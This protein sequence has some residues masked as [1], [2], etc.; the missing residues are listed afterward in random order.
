MISKEHRQQIKLGKNTN[1]D[2]P[3]FSQDCQTDF[4]SRPVT[5]PCQ[6]KFVH[7]MMHV[8][9]PVSLSK[10]RNEIMQRKQVLKRGQLV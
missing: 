2:I 4:D 5:V 10:E 3:V 1:T 7:A 6:E 8:F 9:H